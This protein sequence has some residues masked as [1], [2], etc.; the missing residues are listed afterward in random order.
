MHPEILYDYRMLAALT[1]WQDYCVSLASLDD[2]ACMKLS[3]I[4]SRGGKKD[5]FDL[6][7][8]IINCRSLAE[9][10]ILFREKFQTRDI[11]HVIRSLVYFE[12]ADN[13][14]SL[15]MVTRTSWER[16]KSDF[17]AWVTAADFARAIL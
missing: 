11:G 16:V 1:L 5:F 14:P 7:H 13:E 8:L 15:K 9:Y 17:E 4:T 10:L 12:D 2:I 6:H 3:A